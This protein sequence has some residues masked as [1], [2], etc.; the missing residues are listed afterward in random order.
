[1]PPTTPLT[2]WEVI[3]AQLAE[4]STS[5]DTFDKVKSA[6]DN[7]RGYTNAH[8][9]FPVPL[10][11]SHAFFAGSGGDKS[12]SDAL[13]GAGW[14]L[15]WSKASYHYAMQHPVTGEILTYTEGDVDRGDRS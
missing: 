14:H 12:V 4:I 5:A 3:D 2:F 10:G 1:M 6:L 8:G 15:L 7:R 9:D 11:H 13:R